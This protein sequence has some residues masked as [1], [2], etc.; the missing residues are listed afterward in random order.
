[1]KIIIEQQA[2]TLYSQPQMG[3]TTINIKRCDELCSYN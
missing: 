2:S 1:M 3:I